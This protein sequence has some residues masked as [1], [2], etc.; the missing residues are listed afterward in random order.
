MKK[1]QR[2]TMGNQL[3]RVR[4]ILTKPVRYG[5]LGEERKKKEAREPGG[6]DGY[7]WLRWGAGGH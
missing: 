3:A 1:A 5:V 2:V 6:R 4:N 7:L